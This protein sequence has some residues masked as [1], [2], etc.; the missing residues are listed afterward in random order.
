[1][2]VLPFVL[3]VCVLLRACRA[4]SWLSVVV[5]YDLGRQISQFS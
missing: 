2:R 1:V 5:A 4:M 3:A